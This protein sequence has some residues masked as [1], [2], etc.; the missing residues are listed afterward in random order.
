MLSLR[1]CHCVYLISQ[2][3]SITWT[4]PSTL[5]NIDD[6][7]KLYKKAATT[8]EKT[9]DRTIFENNATDGDSQLWFD[10]VIAIIKH[11]TLLVLLGHGT[12]LRLFVFFFYCFCCL[13][14]I[15][16]AQNRIVFDCL[17]KIVA[18]QRDDHISRIIKFWNWDTHSLDHEELMDVWS[19][20]FGQ[21]HV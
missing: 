20:N 2:G 10:M 11:G 21:R 19:P 14:V 7:N 13:G 17:Q 4:F 5:F 6:C 9:D 1:Q 18:D 12:S 16:S 15:R 3:T 8:K